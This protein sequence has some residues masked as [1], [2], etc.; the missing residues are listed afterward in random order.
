MREDCASTADREKKR[1]QDAAYYLANKQKILAKVKEYYR[2]NLSAKK[3]YALE[4]YKKHRQEVVARYHQNPEISLARSGAWKKNNPRR[5]SEHSQKYYK[6]HLDKI[7][8]Y[9]RAYRKSHPGAHAAIIHK[10]RA[11]QRSA[12]INLAKISEWMRSIRSKSCAKC[13]YCGCKVR[14]KRLHFDH[15]VALANGGAHSVENLCVSCSVCNQ[16]KHTKFI[17]TWVKMGQQVLEL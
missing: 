14:G 8:E 6:S 10:R 12:T 5:H 15:I 16:S 13:Y 4:Y 2:N 7:K 17:R 3:S 11:L 9:A 1:Q